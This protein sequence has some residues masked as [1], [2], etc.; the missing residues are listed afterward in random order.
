MNLFP[1]H[2]QKNA[3]V[4]GSQPRRGVERKKRRISQREKFRSGEKKIKSGNRAPAALAFK[5][6]AQP[7]AQPA[8]WPAGD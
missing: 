3:G 6:A 8:E 4:V 5:P 2:F 1:E 7:A